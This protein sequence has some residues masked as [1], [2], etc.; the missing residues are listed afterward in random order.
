MAQVNIA[1]R[2]VYAELD[3][4]GTTLALSFGQSGGEMLIGDVLGWI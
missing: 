2:G 3:A 1:A 4:Q